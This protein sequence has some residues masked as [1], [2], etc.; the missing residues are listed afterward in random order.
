LA[1]LG[2]VTLAAAVLVWALAASVG[3]DYR[4]VAYDAGAGTGAY[5]VVTVSEGLVGITANRGGGWSG[6]FGPHRYVYHDVSYHGPALWN[7]PFAWPPWAQEDPTM[8]GWDARF[9]L[10]PIAAAC[11]WGSVMLWRQRA[12]QRRAERSGLCACGY[13]RAGLAPGAACPE[14]GTSRVLAQ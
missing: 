12:R 14:C 8:S 5:V 2:A 7:H 11:V 10:W 4:G 9:P 13:S 6:V 1:L 3:L